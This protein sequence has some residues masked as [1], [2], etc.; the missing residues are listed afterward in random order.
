MEYLNKQNF[1]L[2]NRLAEQMAEIALKAHDLEVFSYSV[3]HSLKA[4]LRGIEGY[5]RLLDERY[6]GRLDEEGRTFIRQIRASAAQMDRLIDGLMTYSRLEQTAITPDPVELRQL[7]EALVEEKSPEL[8]EHKIRLAVRIE[9]GLMT[10]DPEG[11]TLALRNYLDNAIKFTRLVPQPRIEI[12]ALE[13]RQSY[14]LW[15]RDN[16]I[17]FDMKYRERIFEIFQC[18]N[19]NHDYPG[20]G[21]GLAIVRMAMNRMNGTAWAISTVGRGSVFFLEIPKKPC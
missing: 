14:R 11:L 3:A 1:E 12:G 4:P 7:I 2:E 20:T 17:G 5:S 6:A 18:L 8:N 10:I 19:R 13:M 9:N 15:V 21:L 16:G